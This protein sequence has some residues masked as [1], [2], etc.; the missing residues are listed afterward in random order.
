[1]ISFQGR[2][3]SLI[4]CYANDQSLCLKQWWSNWYI[5]W[6]SDELKVTNANKINSKWWVSLSAGCYLEHNH[7][8]KSQALGPQSLDEFLA[9]PVSDF[10]ERLQLFKFPSFL[11]LKVVRTSTLTREIPKKAHISSCL[12]VELTLSPIQRGQERGE[13]LLISVPAIENANLHQI[14]FTSWL[15]GILKLRILLSTKNKLATSSHWEYSSEW[16]TK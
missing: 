12:T 9:V 15:A 3:Y 10:C 7:W 6:D 13:K 14:D 11:P 8:N 2:L 4:C 16:S 5:K 1:M